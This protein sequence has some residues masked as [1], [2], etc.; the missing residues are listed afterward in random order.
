[1]RR[2]L[3]GVAVVTLAT[4][5]ASH[6]TPTTPPMPISPPAPPAAPPP[7]GGRPADVIRLGPSAM[8]YTTHQVV[9]IDQE[10]PTGRQQVTYGLRPLSVTIT[11]CRLGWLSH[12][13]QHRFNRPR[14]RD[15]G[16][17]ECRSSRREGL[18]FVGR[19]TRRATRNP[20]P[21]DSVAAQAVS[22]IVGSR[23]FFPGCPRPESRSAQRGPT[24]SL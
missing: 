2:R 12:D 14:L 20:T 8:R 6:A 11:A 15:D 13:G 18:S 24:R 21:P 17:D 1:M 10:Y 5:C 4:A 16:T 3:L 23:N 19:L 22:P 7:A 9:H